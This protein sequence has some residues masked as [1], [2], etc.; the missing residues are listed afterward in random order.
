VFLLSEFLEQIS[1][2]MTRWSS[3]S[4]TFRRSFVHHVRG[5]YS[6]VPARIREVPGFTTLD[7]FAGG[8][9]L[10][11]GF[12]RAGAYEVVAAVE[13][14]EA[15]AATFHAN[16]RP[17]QILVGDIEGWRE[18]IPLV[19]VVLGGPPCQGFSQLG[20]GDP[21]D[22]RNRLWEEYFRVVE[23]ARPR[24]FVLENV[25]AFQR[26]REF[27]DFLSRCSRA[28]YSRPWVGTLNA[29]AYGTP[30][31]RLRTIAIGVRDGARGE[32]DP[33]SA[34]AATI[35]RMDGGGLEAIRYLASEPLTD[36][37]P[38]RSYAFDD[39]HGRE[40]QAAGPFPGSELHLARRPTPE[41][42]ARYRHIKP[43]QNRHALPVHLQTPGWRKHKTGSGDVMGRLEWG[44]PSVTIR[45]EFFKPEKGRYLHPEEDR[46]LTHREAAVLQG[47]SDDYLWCGGKIEIAR[48]IGN[49]VPPPLAEA[50]AKAVL[51]W[52]TAPEDTLTLAAAAPSGQLTFTA[53]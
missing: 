33:A 4:T 17:E 15:A 35:P 24:V 2:R 52:L 42:L 34:I 46:P 8:G 39:V 14:D 16:H 22:P 49:A 18:G 48:Q 13:S 27:P 10:T 21:D 45:T 29:N 43:G 12:R 38:I 31:R 23:L 11:E 41:S 7:L 36:A 9:G 25:T 44:K 20:L 26:S 6:V 40:R 50:I 47:F 19:D 3:R 53:K 32:R 5:R 37:L 1:L 28:G 51:G 30:Q